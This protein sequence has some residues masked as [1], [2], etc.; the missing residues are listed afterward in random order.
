MPTRFCLREVVGRRGL[1]QSELARR[2]GLSMATVN[3]LCT[4]ATTQVSLV[5][6]DKLAAV[7]Q[8]APGDLIEARDPTVKPADAAGDVAR[9]QIESAAPIAQGPWVSSDRLWSLC[10]QRDITFA[11]LLQRAGL[12]PRTV[13]RLAS[14]S[15]ARV[16]P[17]D[18]AKLAKLAVALGVT[19]GDL[20]RGGG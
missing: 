19:P 6:L 11:E 5:T 20:R 8:V 17:R 12:N 18:I 15:A 13:S 16:T 3:R 1:S 14:T 4:N 10:R 2:S 7:L 9:V